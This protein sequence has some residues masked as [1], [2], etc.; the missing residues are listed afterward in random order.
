MEAQLQEW[1]AKLDEHKAKARQAS[2]DAK[3]RYEKQVDELRP[4]L[5]AAQQKLAVDTATRELQK[6]SEEFGSRSADKKPCSTGALTRTPG[7]YEEHAWNNN[8]AAN[9]R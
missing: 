9:R 6:S 1:Q 7:R 4:K 8:D 5:E 2:A 3:L